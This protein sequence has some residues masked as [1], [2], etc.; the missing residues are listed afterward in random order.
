MSSQHNQIVQIYK[1][2]QIILSILESI[3]DYDIGD[4]NGF[5]F[6][7][8][9]AMYKNNQLDMLLTHKII[10]NKQEKTSKTYIKYHTSSTGQ[11]A[12]TIN[13]ISIRNIVEDLYNE[14]D[15][16]TNDDCLF[17]IMEGE[18]NDSMVNLLKFMYN[19]EGKFIIVYNI[20]R[21]QFN[22]LEHSLVPRVTIL[23]DDEINDFKK[24]YNVTTEKDMPEISRFDP[25]AQAICLRPGQICKF[26]RNSPT[27]MET[28]YFRICI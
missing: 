19:N 16:L 1:S 17:I 10:D 28:P 6:N 8:I 18:P 2:R 25:Q 27:S 14:S 24:K 9:D 15:T 13:E 3:Y 26:I 11:I 12:T 23:S 4:Y 21:L 20:K 5:T 22:I 7:E